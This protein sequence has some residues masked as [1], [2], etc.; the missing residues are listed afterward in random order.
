[1]IGRVASRVSHVQAI[2]DEVLPHSGLAF[3]TDQDQ[4]SWAVTRSTP[5]AGLDRLS[6][7]QRVDLTVDH[8]DDFSVASGY[9][10]LD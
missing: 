2:V 6:P 7:G 9:T 8:H 3:L 4:V 1:M 5:G 10:P